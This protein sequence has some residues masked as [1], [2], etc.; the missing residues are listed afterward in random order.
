MEKKEFLC[1]RI[2][3]CNTFAPPPRRKPRY[4]TDT[5]SVA[6]DRPPCVCL[7]CNRQTRVTTSR[8]AAK[9]PINRASRRERLSEVTG[10]KQEKLMLRSAGRA[11]GAP[12]HPKSGHLPRS[13]RTAGPSCGSNTHCNCVTSWLLG[14][15]KCTES[16]L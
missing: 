11:L 7:H 6:A 15:K 9:C 12:E 14:R 10:A 8:K 13:P 2:G 4:A 3:S 16:H 1:T 5:S